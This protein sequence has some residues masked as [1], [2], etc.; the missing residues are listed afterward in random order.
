MSVVTGLPCRF[1][2]G[3]DPVVVT[4]HSEDVETVSDVSGVYYASIL[5]VRVG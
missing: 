3:A 5:E 1:A 4:W 2:V